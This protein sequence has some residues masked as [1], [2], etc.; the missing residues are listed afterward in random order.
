MVGI[1]RNIGTIGLFGM[2]E[3]PRQGHDGVAKFNKVP[4]NS[5]QTCG[6]GHATRRIDELAP[7]FRMR[8]YAHMRAKM[9]SSGTRMAFLASISRK[10]P[11]LQMLLCPPPRLLD[12]YRIR[13]E[14]VLELHF[15]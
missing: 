14:F 1:S 2:S 3:T 12:T 6:T 7:G 11:S 4:A 15:C 13:V 9:R 10:Y 8:H 5:M